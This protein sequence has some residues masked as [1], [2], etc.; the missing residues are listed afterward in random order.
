MGDDQRDVKTTSKKPGMEQQIAAIGEGASHHGCHA[1][2]MSFSR[3][4]WR[5]AAQA[6][7]GPLGA[8]PALLAALRAAG[9]RWIEAAEPAPPGA[10]GERPHHLIVS[11]ERMSKRPRNRGTTRKHRLE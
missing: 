9:L 4:P 10:S 5:A 8:L 3:V 11:A 1:A 6:N 7:S 2:R